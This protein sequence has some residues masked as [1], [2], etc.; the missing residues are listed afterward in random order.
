[1]SRLRLLLSV[2]SDAIFACGHRNLGSLRWYRGGKHL[3]LCQ[4][5]SELVEA[6]LCDPLPGADG[7]SIRPVPPP[8]PEADV[9]RA[10]RIAQARLAHEELLA[11]RGPEAERRTGLERMAERQEPDRAAAELERMVRL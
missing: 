8:R 11:M 7:R 3:A 9:D 6:D 5:C 2:L 4:D 10:A 1:M